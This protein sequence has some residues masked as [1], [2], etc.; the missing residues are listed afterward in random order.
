MV[1]FYALNAESGVELWE[2]TT[3]IGVISSPAVVGGVVYVGSFDGNVYT[4]NAESGVKLWNYTTDSRVWSS[5]AV[6][7]GVV[8]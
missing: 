5:P 6:V 7:G 4:L 1:T 8:Y 2:Y 3:S